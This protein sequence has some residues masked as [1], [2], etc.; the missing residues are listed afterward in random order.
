MKKIMCLPVV[1]LVSQFCVSSSWA[2]GSYFKISGDK[3]QQT[4]ER[5][6][7]TAN[8]AVGESL[9]IIAKG[10]AYPSVEFQGTPS[11]QEL[12]EARK[13]GPFKARAGTWM[14]D[15]KKLR[16]VS[17]TSDPMQHTIVLEATAPGQ[18]TVRFVGVLL[19]VESC[20]I[21]VTVD[22]QKKARR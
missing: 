21:Q 9:E 8:I 20:E 6:P 3:I 17:T 11:P 7:Y 22:E 12:A 13:H 1:M 5:G 16:L 10:F 15:D 19:G 4:D 14:F 18:Y 2:S